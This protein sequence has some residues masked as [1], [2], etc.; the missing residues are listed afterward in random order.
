LTR[1][2][3]R[4]KGARPL[5]HGVEQ[6]KGP[7]S[8]FRRRLAIGANAPFKRLHDRYV[9]G[10]G[11]R[12]RDPRD[13]AGDDFHLRERRPFVIAGNARRATA[14]QLMGSQRRDRDKL[15]GIGC[16]CSMNDGH[17]H[18][19]KINGLGTL[20]RLGLGQALAERGG[21]RLRK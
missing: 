12:R 5:F 13:F 16:L 11:G 4:E 20:K 19:Q 3:T 6:E 1:V 14:P 10:E 18:L 17:T 2:H 9:W 15:E 8:F 21:G 7:G